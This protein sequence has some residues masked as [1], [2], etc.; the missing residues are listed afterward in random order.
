[1]HTIYLAFDII[2]ERVSSMVF[3]E[4]R[5]SSSFFSERREDCVKI[6]LLWAQDPRPVS[7][8]ICTPV[9]WKIISET[10]FET[11]PCD[12][13]LVA[14]RVRPLFSMVIFLT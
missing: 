6:L 7:R 10:A 12:K 13:Q 1:V 14:R 8:A 3:E 4:R 2:L 5:D 11:Y 9:Q